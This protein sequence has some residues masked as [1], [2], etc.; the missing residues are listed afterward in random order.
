MQQKYY[1]SIPQFVLIAFLGSIVFLATIVWPFWNLIPEQVTETVEI[2][3]KDK[4]GNCVIETSDQ[5]LIP[6]GE[7]EENVGDTVS[8]T[9]DEKTKTRITR[10]LP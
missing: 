10:Y 8:M 5:Y 2:V 9:Y 3:Y 6:I 7:C 1:Q 4:A